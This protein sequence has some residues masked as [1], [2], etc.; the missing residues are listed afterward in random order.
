MGE[1]IELIIKIL[2]I[3]GSDSTSNPDP[4][5]GRPLY[6]PKHAPLIHMLV[7]VTCCLRGVPGCTFSNRLIGSCYSVTDILHA[8]EFSAFMLM[9]TVTLFAPPIDSL[10]LLLESNRLTRLHPGCNYWIYWLWP[11]APLII[12]QLA[13]I[14]TTRILYFSSMRPAWFHS[15]KPPEKW[16]SGS[17]RMKFLL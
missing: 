13:A 16:S 12:S 17:C 7:R 10:R 4:S 9:R 3:D 2:T 11:L 14:Q 15:R 5:S 1:S 6:R 8:F